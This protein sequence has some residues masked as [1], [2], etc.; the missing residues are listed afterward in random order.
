MIDM[1]LVTMAVLGC[2][3]ERCERELEEFESWK[4]V[5]RRLLC[6]GVDIAIPGSDRTAT[7]HGLPLVFG[8]DTSDY[9]LM[10]NGK[11]WVWV[12]PSRPIGVV[13]SVNQDGTCQVEMYGSV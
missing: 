9:V 1:G 6:I 2:H 8:G 13:R 12:K 7:F 10:N 11:E 4:T 3:T 5:K